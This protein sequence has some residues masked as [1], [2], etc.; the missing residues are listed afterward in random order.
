MLSTILDLYALLRTCSPE[1]APIVRARIAALCL[2]G[3]G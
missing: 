2:R 1:Q 3:R